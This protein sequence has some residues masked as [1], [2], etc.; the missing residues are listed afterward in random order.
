MAPFCLF[1][2]GEEMSWGQRLIGYSPPEFFLANNFQQEL[3]L[4][5]LSQSVQP[6]SFLMLALAGYGVLLPLAQAESLR[7]VL[8]RVGATPPPLALV[9]WF[10]VAI[11]LLWDYPFSFTGEWV[12]LFAGGLFVM[13]TRPAPTAF[14]TI[15][16]TAVAFGATM[17]PLAGALERG[18]DEIRIVCARAEGQGLADDVGA[19]EAGMDKLWGMRRVHK[20]VWTSISEDYIDSDQFRRFNAATCLDAAGAA[21]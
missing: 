12:E 6:G 4:H 21:A 7:R 17:T 16:A 9:P 13:S 3:T 5:N 20:R 11:V 15:I 18:R 10:V 8:R 14:W 1:V 2:A 19:G